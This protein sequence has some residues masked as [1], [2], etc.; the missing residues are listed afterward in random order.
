MPFP[1][2]RRAFLAT[3]AAGAASAAWPHAFAGPTATTWP[4]YRDALVVDACASP[5][6][7]ERE[8]HP[9]DAA[10]LADIRAGGVTAINFTVGSVGSYDDDFEQT[11]RSIAFWDAQVAAHPDA[12]LKV[13]RGAQLDEAKRSGRLGI[14][15]GFQDTTMYGENLERFDV[16]H[17]LG[18]RIVQLTYN[19]RNLVG[20]GCLEPGN[21]GLSRF[22][23]E[24]VARINER[25]ALVDLSHCGQRTTREGILASR[26]PVAITH[27][28]CAAVAGSPRNK[29]DEE[30][31]LL[32]ER[33]GVVG[34]YV[35]PYLRTQGQVQADDVI[36]H[37][38][39]ALDVC[40]EDHVGIGTDGTTS[41]VEITAAYKKQFADEIAER[42]RRGIAA[43]GERADSFTFAPDLNTPT[44]FERLAL[45]L[46]QR[47]HS[48]ARIEKVLGANFARLFRDVI[49]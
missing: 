17:D 26:R 9:L 18:V 46:S 32:A 21:A 37:L 5:G 40:G 2:G 33:G 41:G 39:H 1:T 15:F 22:G 49:A 13:V 36:R 12:L 6:R 23:L 25:S 4:R 7:P 10:E 48:D 24:L 28:G 29:R 11:L 8:P 3:C 16:F 38:E 19:R 43:P 35:M 47:G 31:R 27:S 14:V 34:I 42:A 45:L 30:L 20:D 44:R